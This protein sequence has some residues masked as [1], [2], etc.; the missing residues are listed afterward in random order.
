MGAVKGGSGCGGCEGGEVGVG[1]EVSRAQES[2][3]ATVSEH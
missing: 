3:S 1:E 2:Q